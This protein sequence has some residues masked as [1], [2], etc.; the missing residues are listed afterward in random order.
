MTSNLGFSEAM[1]HKNKVGYVNNNIGNEDVKNVINKHFRPEFINRI[2]D[3]VYFQ[4]LSKEVCEKL[5]NRYVYEYQNKLNVELENK[6]I[7]DNVLLDKEAIRYGARGIKR[8]VKQE[9]LMQ[10]EERV[11]Y[12]R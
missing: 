9:I 6:Q 12:K 7:I 2:D 1:F 5:I 8:K 3:I 4:T 10:L 11:V